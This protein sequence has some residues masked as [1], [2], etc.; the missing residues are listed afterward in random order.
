[1]ARAAKIADGRTIELSVDGMTCA[2]CA[3]GVERV[4]RSQR[5]VLAAR[6]EFMTG[7]A[8][9]EAESSADPA[10]L[11]SAVTAAGY[12]AHVAV[13][14]GA[15]SRLDEL[16]RAGRDALR[17][18]RGRTLLAVAAC[19]PLSWIAMRS[20]HL[21][22]P[23]A[24]DAAREAAREA[25]AAAWMAAGDMRLSM[26]QWQSV[27]AQFLLSTPIVLWFAWPI[28]RSAWKAT[29]ARTVN[30]DSLLA[31][32]IGVSYAWSS[33]VV[34]IGFL[35]VAGGGT[36]PAVHFEAAGVIATLALVG[37]WLETRASMRTRDAVRGLADLQPTC[38]RVRRDGADS[39]VALVD[40]RPDDLV[41]VRPG[42]RVPVDG[43]VEEGASEVDQSLLTG[44][45]VPVAKRPGDEAF[46]GTLNTSGAIVIR[47][48]AV[49]MH[50]VLQ[51]IVRMVAESQARRAPIARIADRVSAWFTFA[52]L[53]IAAATAGAWAVAGDPWRGFGC[54]VA[55]LVVACPCALGLAT[56][57]AVMVATGAAAR[58]GIL[59]KGGAAL[60]ALAAVDTAILDK[61]GTVTAGR[62][63]VVAVHAVGSMDLD[64]VL[65]LASGAERLSE[66]PLG[67]AVVRAAT[68]RALRI[69]QAIEFSAE[70]GAG[71]RAIVDRRRV[72]V[73][74]PWFACGASGAGIRASRML[75]DARSRGRTAVVVAVD[76]TAQAVIELADLV[77]P[78]ARASVER[79]R[80]IGVEVGMSSGDDPRVVR[81]V[82][83][84][85]GIADAH[86]DERPDA[87][88]ARVRAAQA[89]GRR[90]T[91]VGDGVNDAPALACA[92]VGI[93]VG[94]GADIA[95]DS[96]DVVLMRPGISGVADAI[97]LARRTMRVIR[98]NL[99]WA[100]GYNLI[101]IPAA[102]GVLVPVIGWQP[103]AGLAAA[104]MACSSLAVLANSLRLRGAVP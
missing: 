82:A 18:L 74:T 19:V 32:G 61:T 80:S 16:D 104:A 27:H 10:A 21:W 33:F 29:A 77:L 92:D 12:P 59:V 52:V 35:P 85:A 102:A 70:P 5:G 60:E 76:G 23:H 6:V 17:A 69:P 103:G 66:H 34:L 30:M 83:E 87:K 100:F 95:A 51:R 84:A 93:A 2:G 94:Q 89:N 46:A 15:G 13:G 72:A 8:T 37:R 38:A 55:V 47:A 26:E 3:T 78:D 90:V 79:L 9:V 56:P 98:Q 65:A 20:H 88:A 81:T 1:M 4:L 24:R 53:G 50:S 63:E 39:D 71:V 67:E 58:R 40:V 42:E 25:G 31:L 54:A 49:G 73:G 14:S 48:T 86:G 44:E 101:A 97:V 45:S 28:L 7:R 36:V 62:P 43:R 64:A 41:V 75:D 96:A 11:A 57:A 22:E 91:M 99:W 68:Q